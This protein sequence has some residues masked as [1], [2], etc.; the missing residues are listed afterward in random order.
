MEDIE[1]TLDA[2][3]GIRERL[4]KWSIQKMSAALTAAMGE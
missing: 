1:I 3:S 4:E 2:F